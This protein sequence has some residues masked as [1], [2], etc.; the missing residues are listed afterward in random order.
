MENLRRPRVHAS[1][2]QQKPNFLTGADLV[3]AQ[4][5][6]YVTYAAMQESIGRE[7]SLSK[8]LAREYRAKA[9][10]LRKVFNTAWWN[11]ASNRFYSGILPD[12]SMAEEFVPECN[13]YALAVRHTGGRSEDRR[14][15]SI[16]WR[17]SGR[18]FPER[19]PICRKC[20]I[21]TAETIAPTGF[22][23]E[24]AGDNFFGKDQGEVAFAVI[25]ARRNRFDG[26]YSG[27]AEIDG[28][29]LAAAR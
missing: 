27:R 2:F 10:G 23:S 21:G 29:D 25:G 8:R 18:S 16:R 13:M 11:A 15:R 14:P 7:G 4:Y 9:D 12:R 19:I 22:C 20:S 24:I 26:P 28:G 3:A 6:G 5:A 17:R 1:Y